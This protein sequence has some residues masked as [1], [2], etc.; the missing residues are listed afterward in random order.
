[1]INRL[2]NENYLKI[3]FLNGLIVALIKI[4]GISL[5]TSPVNII[6]FSFLP[7]FLYQFI[8][9]KSSKT[10]SIISFFLLYIIIKFFILKHFNLT[11]SF[12]LLHD[13]LAYTSFNYFFNLNQHEKLKLLL[14]F[15]KFSYF[16]ILVFFL[17]YF[18]RTVLPSAFTDI[19]N[20]FVDIGVEKYT[21]LV[22]NTALYRPNGLIGNPITFG[23][24]INLLLA[25]EYFYIRIVKNTIISRIIIIILLLMIFLLFSRANIV[26][27]LLVGMFSLFK[28]KNIIK[29]SLISSIFLIF[30]I[31]LNSYL[32]SSVTE[33][34][35]NYDRIFGVDERAIKSTESHLEDYFNAYKTFLKSPVFGTST[36]KLI[37]EK[38]ITDGAIF[39]LLLKY[40]AFG[41]LFTLTMYFSI[42]K[43]YIKQLKVSYV[44]FPLYIFIL[45]ASVYSYLNSAILNKGVYLIL[46]LFIG[47]T[48]NLNLTKIKR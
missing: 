10:K 1:M 17:Q 15:R 13:I 2:L 3:I 28:K 20:L 43:T 6:T 26:F 48:S 40:G 29:I 21:A 41:F 27:A 4:S 24:V 47:I 12:H 32:Y 25:I 33:Y 30:I 45:F 34:K 18:F 8:K 9:S 7:L 42:L 19:P 16:F 46:F 22:Y 23:F 38:I 31:P 35:Y 14:L 37:D 39:S 44:T 11:D 5:P 36:S